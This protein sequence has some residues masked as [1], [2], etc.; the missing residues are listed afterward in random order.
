MERLI[1]IL[2]PFLIFSSLRGIIILS[3]NFESNWG[4]YGN[5]PPTGWS[6]IDQGNESP[7]TWNTNDW[8]KYNYGGTQGNIARVYYSP[9]ENQKE[10]LITPLLDFS[11]ASACSL[12]FWNYYDDYSG[13]QTDT[14]YVLLSTDGGS[15]FSNII[16]IFTYDDLGNIRTYDLSSYI[17]QTNVKIAFKYVGNNDWEWGI[18]NV[19][20]TKT[21]SKPNDVGVKI[22]SFTPINPIVGKNITISALIRNYG[23]NN[24][25][26]VPVRCKIKR[27]TDGTWVFNN[28][29]T[30][31]TLPSG[32][33]STKVWNY[34]PL[35]GGEYYVVDTTEL[36]GDEVSGNDKKTGRFTAIPVIVPDWSD[37]YDL[38]GN[39]G[40][41]T[42]SGIYDEWELGTP[43]RGPGS[44]YSPPNCFATDLDNTYENNS[45]NY[46][47]SPYI[48]LSSFNPLNDSVF[49]SF[50]HFD[51]LET[52]Y[53]Y[54]YV[55]IS[56]D[57]L[58]WNDL[59]TF[60]GYLASWVLHTL[61]I[62]PIY[63][64][65][66]I[67]VRFRLKTDGSVQKAGFH[68]DN[69]SVFYKLS[70]PY[71][72]PL[73]TDSDGN[74]TVYWS[75]VKNA[76]RYV[77]W[78]LSSP[79]LLLND[80]CDNL[81]NWST[82]FFIPTGEAAFSE[83][84][85]FW[86]GEN[87][88]NYSSY[89]STKV[90]YFIEEGGK[91][92]F[93]TKYS[94]S[95]NDVIYFEISDNNGISWNVLWEQRGGNSNWIKKEYSLIS[96]AGKSVKF[97]F[98]FIG[99][100]I[101]DPGFYF[102]DFKVWSFS[103]KTLISNNIT[104]TFYNIT[105]KSP[106]KYFYVA[107]S[108]KNSPYKESKDSNLEDIIVRPSNLSPTITIN[109][110]NSNI[111]ADGYVWIKWID[112]DLDD[113][114][115]ISLFYDN[116][117][118]GYDGTLIVS[119]ISEDSP[120]D[121]F[122]WDTR[123]LTP[124]NYYIY[125]KISDQFIT[126]NSNYSARIR[127]QALNPPAE[128][129]PTGLDTVKNRWVKI[130]ATDNN[131]DGSIAHFSNEEGDTAVTSDD[132]LNILFGTSF[133][134]W[135]SDA[136]IR[137]DGQNF[138]Y[139]KPGEGVREVSLK[140]LIGNQNIPTT[141]P[142]N[143]VMPD[144]ST[145]LTQTWWYNGVSVRQ[146]LIF[147]YGYYSYGPAWGNSRQ[148]YDQIL[149]RYTFK[150][151]SLSPKWVGLRIEWD[152]EIDVYDGA[153]IKPENESI[154]LTNEKFYSPNL[155]NFFVCQDSIPGSHETPLART[156]GYLKDFGVATNPDAL[157]IIHWVHPNT[158]PGYSY[159][160]DS[161]RAIGTDSAILLWYYPV[162]LN[163]GDSITFSTYYGSVRYDI[164]KQ[165]GEEG[166]FFILIPQGNSVIL[167][168][169][170][171]TGEYFEIFRK[172]ENTDYEKIAS[173]QK[174]NNTYKDENLQEGE[175][176][177]KIDIKENGETIK[178]LGPLTVYI[179]GLKFTITEPY[180]NPFKK[181][182]FFKVFI[183]E[184]GEFLLEIF[185]NSGRRIHLKK[186]LI[187]SPGIYKITLDTDEIKLPKGTFFLKGKYKEKEIIKKLIKI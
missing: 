62:P 65:D 17:G 168:W 154:F 177:Y 151:K 128:Q 79:N 51:S 173:L 175:Y 99:D 41:W 40:G 39:P 97:R 78:E 91:V 116:N 8:Y 180:P 152:I 145:G 111:N 171:N 85:C 28:L 127:L 155:N 125:A 113:D 115:V 126:I 83:G 117:Q 133:S 103:S 95:S 22:L 96:Y 170:S 164:L 43:V 106:G 87:T 48:N 146:D 108:I 69:F 11:G 160:V 37:N 67:R 153:I 157:A 132:G 27:E 120:S 49:I 81:N 61:L 167:K 98:R 184:K 129:N 4:P 84:Y 114:A 130:I 70:P 31:L 32:A 174:G 56:R 23:T 38:Q 119:G 15:T 144:N 100:A 124:G 10:W 165:L 59:D 75:K 73:G 118:A 47:F 74:Y 77:L 162:A 176:N 7:P 9:I 148:H 66:T 149:T 140:R 141:Q 54:I 90:S 12:Y 57:N 44:S 161:S 156:M 76:D 20:V 139:A 50:Y 14:G 89:I 138:I 158:Y 5:N 6:I 53:D 135:S 29:K 104:D 109:F 179:K 163:P 92:E 80:P 150:N 55:Q 123:G 159:R 183:P 46:L 45:D 169:K 26:N 94:L 2:I 35:I 147:A 13:D 16:A 134:P 58:N 122:R 142:N 187:K 3:E 185:D 102:D 86:S 143:P 181:F 136:V 63:Y 178:T 71:I 33:E 42:H 34:T 1:K 82:D 68:V 112:E 88:N 21:I 19:V 24:Q 64:G 72:Y 121:S 60:T 166:T 93:N 30:I 182:F 101:D 18:D 110:P 107:R 105:G 131:T 172:K 25:S 186:Y 52:N 137:I 36:T